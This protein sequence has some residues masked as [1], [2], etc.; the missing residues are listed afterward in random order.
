MERI[1]EEKRAKYMITI[2]PE[3]KHKVK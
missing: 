1:V 2:P 3:M